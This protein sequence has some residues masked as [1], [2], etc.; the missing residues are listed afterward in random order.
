MSKIKDKFKK[1]C[2]NS[3]LCAIMNSRGITL[4]TLVVTIVVLLI[5]AGVATFSGIEAIDNTKRTKFIA[6]LKIMQSYVNQWYEDCK[7]NNVQTW[8]GN[9]EAKF[10]DSGAIWLG[11]TNTDNSATIEK[12]KNTLTTAGIT[13]SANNFYYLSSNTLNSLGVEG[14]SQDVLVSIQDRKVVSYLGLKYKNAMYYTI[15]SLNGENG[16]DAIYNAGYENKNTGNINFDLTYNYI[17]NNNAKVSI[18]NIR[19]DGYNKKWKVKY[20]LNNENWNTSDD[21]SFII[22]KYGN[23][24]IGLY[25]ENISQNVLANT[26]KGEIPSYKCKV[27]NESI[28]NMVKYPKATEST[29]GYSANYSGTWKIFYADEEELLIIPTNVI[30]GTSLG[31]N[32]GI[33]LSE[34]PVSEVMKNG[35]YGGKWNKTWLNTPGAVTNGN[36]HKAVAYLCDSDNWK[37][38]VA[39][40]RTKPIISNSYA[41]GAPTLELFV[42]SWN[43]IVDSS[44]VISTPLSTTAY[45]YT[46]TIISEIT[47]NEANGLY[48]PNETGNYWLA[49][50]HGSSSNNN[51]VFFVNRNSKSLDNYGYS[52]NINFRPIVS[53]PLSNVKITENENEGEISYTIDVG[54][55]TD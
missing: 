42:S 32:S 18:S 20:K 52:N 38:F 19:Y 36:K 43:K 48:Y 6:E 31:Y 14:V 28:G 12:A 7:P 45:G 33:P 26:W 23:Y 15:D 5:L 10:S 46:T 16:I 50:P 53:I 39:T 34:K 22:N 11:S 8:S 29:P 2:A 24:E 51:I 4:T 40:D 44:K 3:G 30:S 9:I 47:T 25:N 21:L 13:L 55:G 27:L 54:F 49:S 17:D 35:I 41:V 1:H 37:D